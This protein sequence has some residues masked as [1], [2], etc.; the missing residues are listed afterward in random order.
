MASFLTTYEAVSRSRNTTETLRDLR[1]ADMTESTKAVKRLS[2]VSK[3]QSE[4]QILS[5]DRPG[6]T[7]IESAV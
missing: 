4:I 5:N 2:V 6:V 7:W 1:R 3:S